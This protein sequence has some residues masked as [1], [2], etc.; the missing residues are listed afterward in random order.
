MKL[1]LIEFPSSMFTVTGHQLSA[2]AS[3]MGNRHLQPLYDDAA[4]VGFAIKSDKTGNVVIFSVV[5]VKRDGEGELQYWT[6]AATAD[7]IRKYPECRKVQVLVF[8]D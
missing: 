4:D 2:E 8:N 1:N 5:D 3:D 7:C 6:Y